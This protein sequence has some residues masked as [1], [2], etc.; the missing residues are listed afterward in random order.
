MIAMRPDEIEVRRRHK[1]VVM[2]G[3]DFLKSKGLWEEFLS[4]ATQKREKEDNERYEGY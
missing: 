3:E 1:L 4:Y 2:Y